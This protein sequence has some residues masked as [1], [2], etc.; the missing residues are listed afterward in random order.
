MRIAALL[1]L[2]LSFNARAESPDYLA[3]E[4]VD[5]H[6]EQL[7]Y[8]G[9]FS[10]YVMVG[11]LKSPE[12]A[13][14]ASRIL[15]RE[16]GS[17]SLAL[18]KTRKLV[19]HAHGYDPLHITSTNIISSGVVDAGT[20]TFSKSTAEN[21]R[22]LRAQI[23]AQGEDTPV[24]A[25]LV[26]TNEDYVWEDHGHECGAAVTIPV[27]EW[28]LRGGGPIS[29]ADLSRA[30]YQLI[31]SA[32]GHIRQSI[33]LDPQTND[34]IEF[35]LILLMKAPR[36]EIA[37]RS[38]VR[39]NGGDWMVDAEP[40]TATI[41]CD[42]AAEFK[43]TSER[44]GLGNSLELRMKPLNDGVQASFFYWGEDNFRELNG[45]DLKY[46]RF[47]ELDLDAVPGNPRVTLRSGA[48]YLFRK[49]DVNGT[50]IELLFTPR[51]L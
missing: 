19:F 23:A 8:W 14:V 18:H 17:Y 37:Y 41:S 15:V 33:R 29:L 16:D 34:A 4:R 46:A 13:R 22:T 6:M 31:I 40:K 7:S 27:K 2:V 35:D 47:D 45:L 12:D 28:K 26:I 48:T 24:R 3:M 21:L 30:P 9:L 42:G 25:R 39:H 1:A 50:D 11:K 44:D 5:E 43:F 10:G 38:R 20:S 36:L 32:P 51:T 49:R